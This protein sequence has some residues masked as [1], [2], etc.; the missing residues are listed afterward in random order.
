[1]NLLQNISIKVRLSF[2]AL[3]ATVLL[4]LIGFLGLQS[5]A[6]SNYVLQDIYENDMVAADSIENM[7]QNIQNSRLELLLALQHDPKS[8]FLNLHNHPLEQHTEIIKSISSRIDELWKNFNSTEHSGEEGRLAQ[9]F[10]E[11]RQGYL[12]SLNKVV[13]HLNQGGFYEANKELLINLNPSMNKTIALGNQL[14][15][16]IFS[17]AE[18]E[19]LQAEAN[20]AKSKTINIS[21]IAIA[22]AL[23]LAITWATVQ[24]IALAV[25][26]L[27]KVSKQMAEGDL[28]VRSDYAGRDEL[29]IIARS[30]NLMGDNFSAAISQLGKATDQL[31][32][33]ANQAAVVSEQTG[34]NI[35]RQQA[36][37]EMVASAMNEMV[38]TVQEVASSAEQA[39]GAATNADKE[40]TIGGQ[41]V[42]STIKAIENLANEIERA[43][44][45]IETLK[46]E[47]EAVTGVLDV[48]GGIAEQTN[49]LALNAA[50]EAARAGEHGRGFAVVAD[51]V[52]S[53]ASRTQ[54][55]TS[56]IQGMLGRLQQGADNAVKAMESSQK[57]ARKG[58]E[59]AANAGLALD[60]I[61]VAVDAINNLNA[62]IASAAEQ[63]TAVAEEIN[64]NI[65]NI[66]EIALETSAGSEQTAQAGQ[67]VTHLAQELKRLAN[68]FK[69]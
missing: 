42:S 29:G 48:I 3:L 38:A 22:I 4:I 11:S 57:Q 34:T 46:K 2:M 9:K 7:I 25:N 52:R 68:Q 31:S 23:T 50:I 51:E 64:R 16:L 58:V 44:A 15:A 20:Y 14:A 1:M 60:A 30:F 28:R 17:G 54:E 47:S 40:A 18:Q 63:Q 32:H 61:T 66:S 5:T 59:E 33:A 43:A 12:G 35:A 10:W 49:L 24:G 55:S 27:E 53:L 26:S 41:V 69:T 21:V 67:Q 6:K 56:E 45:V 8:N 65:V 13:S 39:A 37:T 19:Y 36:E 62:Q